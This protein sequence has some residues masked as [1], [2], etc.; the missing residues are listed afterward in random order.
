LT[1]KNYWSMGKK[2]KKWKIFKKNVFKWNSF[3]DGFF[4]GI[5]SF[6]MCCII[7]RIMNFIFECEIFKGES[8]SLNSGVVYLLM[9]V[10]KRETPFCVRTIQLGQ[11]GQIW[12]E[13]ALTVSW[14]RLM[15]HFMPKIAACRSVLLRL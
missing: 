13:D 12:H 4:L 7:L 11:L 9:S 5:S 2:V 10:F 1:R 14:R 6:L 3:S 8:R 15:L